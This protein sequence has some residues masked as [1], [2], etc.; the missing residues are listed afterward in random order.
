M[1]QQDDHNVSAGQAANEVRDVL[2]D[3]GV[4]G[5]LL[6][7]SFSTFITIR[8]VKVLYILMLA[9]IALGWLFMVIGAFSR[10]PVA[11]LGALILGTLGAIIYVIFA[12]ISLEMIVVIFRIGENTSIIAQSKR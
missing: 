6:D 7:F 2:S 11:G 10:G 5:G 9:L 12:R 3:T 1:E 4:F 8:I